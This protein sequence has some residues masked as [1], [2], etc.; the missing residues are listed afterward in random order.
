LIRPTVKDLSNV[1]KNSKSRKKYKRIPTEICLAK[2]NN[3]SNSNNRTNT[4]KTT[5]M[6]TSHAEKPTTSWQSCSFHTANNVPFINVGFP[7]EIQ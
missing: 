4:I 5:T 3:W 2:K 1:T 7:F 6:V